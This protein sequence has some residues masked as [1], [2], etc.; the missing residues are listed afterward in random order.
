VEQGERPGMHACEGRGVT[1]EEYR[2]RLES[3]IFPLTIEM[4]GGLPNDSRAYYEGHKP[5]FDAHIDLWNEFL[6]KERIGLVYD[7]GTCVPFTSYYF[8]VTQGATV[9]YGMLGNTK[10]VNEKVRSI[11][12]N[13]CTDSPPLELADLVICTEC[14]EHLACN[15]YKVRE[16][17][18]SLVRPGGFMLLSFP[19][20]GRNAADYW[21]DKLADYDKCQD[22]IREFTLDT[23]KEF[24]YGTG[25]DVLKEV[26]TQ[27]PAYGT[28][29]MN[30]LLQRPA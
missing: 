2:I 12:I 21:K 4:I 3:D 10:C 16:Y 23:A 14:L 8:H 22:H 9:I 20:G 15:L 24:Y 6:D 1:K 19:C 7:L 17:L 29:I 5:R 25:W 18:K 11:R 30:V 13:L 26:P 27:Q 28:T